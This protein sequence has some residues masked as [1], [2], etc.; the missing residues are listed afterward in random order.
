MP[1]VTMT[2]GSSAD[3][4]GSE[5]V[6]P[7][8]AGVTVHGSRNT[9]LQQMANGLSLT[10]FHTGL[11]ARRGQHRAIP[12]DCDRLRGGRRGAGL[13]G[14]RMNLIPA[15]G[16]NILL[17]GA[18]GVHDRFAPGQQ[19]LGGVGAAWPGCTKQ[20]QAIWDV[21]PTLGGPIKRDK[22]WF[23][24]TGRHTDRGN[25]L[26]L[27]E[28]KRRQ[29]N[30]WTYEPRHDGPA[31]HQRGECMVGRRARHLAGDAE[32]QFNV[33]YEANEVCTQPGECRPCPESA[34]NTYFGVKN[35]VTIDWA[36]PMTSRVLLDGSVLM[37]RLPRI[38]N[39]EGS[40]LIAVQEQSTGL[41]YR[42]MSSSQEGL[43]TAR[44]RLAASYVS[45][46]YARSRSASMAA[47]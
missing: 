26:H 14:V 22:L 41:T 45:G 35:S 28:Q 24:A 12:G 1:A 13:S 25:S 8:G 4:G 23:F 46:L 15:E 42:G 39:P 7:T 21:N 31:G 5:G 30:A 43:F 9:D 34:D 44:V 19:L 11:P 47:R 18:H 10:N 40:W 37:D 36:A 16:G 6:R 20:A 29:R 38:G 2:G 33:G 27:R 17:D 3:I 32:A